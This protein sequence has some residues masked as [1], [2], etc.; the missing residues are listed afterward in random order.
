MYHK[1]NIK[2]W[3]LINH[4]FHIN[5]LETII[6]LASVNTKVRLSQ[7]VE[8]ELDYSSSIVFFGVCSLSRKQSIASNITDEKNEWF[9]PTD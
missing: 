5:L 4:I 7:V 9:R 3:W 2:Y 8:V 6:R 1:D